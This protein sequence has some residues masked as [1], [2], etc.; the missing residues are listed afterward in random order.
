MANMERNDVRAEVE[1]LRSEVRRLRRGGLAAGLLALGA[2]ALGLRPAEPEVLRVRGLVVEDA[3][4]RERILIGAP[5]PAA[6]NRIRTDRERAEEAWGA[7][8]PNMDWYG[9]LDHSANGILVLDENGHDRIAIGAPTPDPNVGQRI[10]P[11]VGISIHDEEGYERAGW[12]HMPALDRVNFGLDHRH[13]EGLN[14]FLLEDGTSGMLVR[15]EGSGTFVGLAQ[16]NGIVPGL[17]KPLNGVAVIEGGR[18]PVVLDGRG[19]D[20]RVEVRGEDGV[21]TGSLGQ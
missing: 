12:G 6:P 11:G 19:D 5:I 14:L 18:L 2:L 15:D 8:F 21:V 3:E 4:G 1:R 7:G 16:P 10:A 17:E 20:P 13:G 9:R